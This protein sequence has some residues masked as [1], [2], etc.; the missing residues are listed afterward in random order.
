MKTPLPSELKS[1]PDAEPRVEVSSKGHETLIRLFDL[2]LDVSNSSGALNGGGSADAV[3][4]L[5]VSSVL[6]R[7]CVP[8][9][10]NLQNSQVP[11]HACGH[12]AVATHM[13]ANPKAHRTLIGSLL[14]KSSLH[15]LP[16]LWSI[17]VDYMSFVGPRSALFNQHDLI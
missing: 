16:Q 4:N 9:K 3:D 10:Q 2:V 14:F 7:P 13:L 5:W 17:L 1:T 12:P 8:T 11:Q 6:I 15:E